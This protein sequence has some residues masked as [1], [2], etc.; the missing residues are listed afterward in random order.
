[1]R[2]V[3]LLAEDILRIENKHIH[4]ERTCLLLLLYSLFLLSFSKAPCADLFDNENFFPFIYRSSHMSRGYCSIFVDFQNNRV[5]K[6]VNPLSTSKPNNCQGR[7]MPNLPWVREKESP[8]S[9]RLIFW[10][11]ESNRQKQPKFSLFWASFKYVK[12]KNTKK[13]VHRN[14]WWLLF[15]S[16]IKKL[17][18]IVKRIHNTLK[19]KRCIKKQK[20]KRKLRG[21]NAKKIDKCTLRE[22][23]ERRV[24]RVVITSRLTS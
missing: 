20:K 15:A 1:M 23:D 17:K 12:K 16:G 14:S 2:A 6:N 3:S 18:K 9:E 22:F 10:K 5:E 11:I 8:I 19:S 24:R 7:N 13:S 4:A 21:G